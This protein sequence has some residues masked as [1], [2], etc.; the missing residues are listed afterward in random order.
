MALKDDAGLVKCYAMLN[1]EKYQNMAI[2]DS[3]FNVNLIISSFLRIMELLI[4]LRRRLLTQ[5]V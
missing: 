3:F 2:G 5:K 4:N 1:I